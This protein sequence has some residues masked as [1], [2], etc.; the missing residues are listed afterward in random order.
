MPHTPD[1]GEQ[2]IREDDGLAAVMLNRTPNGVLVTDTDG[3]IRVCNRSMRRMVPTVP[4]PIGRYP[5]E[6]MPV[7]QLAEALAPATTGEVELQFRLGSRDLY[8]TVVPMGPRRGRLAIVQDV[9]RIR[10]AERY[11]REFVANVSH[12][13]RTPATAISGYAETLLADRDRLPEDVVRM[14][15]VISRNGQRL[16]DL[17]DDLLQL[18]RLDAMEQAPPLSAVNLRNIAAEAIDKQAALAEQR[19]ITLELDVPSHLEVSANRDALDHVLANLASNAVKYSHEGGTVRI[20]ARPADDNVVCIDV[21]DDGIGI[22]PKHHERIFNR[23]WRVDKG[24]SRDAG[25][26][27]LGLAIVKHLT[28]AMKGRI[29]VRSRLGRGSTFRLTLR[30][31]R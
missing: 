8:V 21:I 6:A 19:E 12:E 16:T 27:G 2:A 28:K 18:A 26:T 29:E 25:G 14:I 1:T 7:P 17:F 20:K 23:F 3:R 15:E 22:D 31:V 9:T 10:Q 4:S 5:I 13:L 11:R 30:G 24:R